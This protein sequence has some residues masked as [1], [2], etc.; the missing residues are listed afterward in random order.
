VSLLAAAV[1]CRPSFLA[2]RI[3]AGA[4]GPRILPFESPRKPDQV[5][6]RRHPPAPRAASMR[7]RG[8]AGKPHP[9]SVLAV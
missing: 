8:A 2:S 4:L 7:M 1:W 9:A 3:R 6:S 5:E